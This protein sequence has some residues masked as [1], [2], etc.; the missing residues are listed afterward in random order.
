MAHG[1]GF[2]HGDKRVIPHLSAKEKAMCTPGA[3]SEHKELTSHVQPQRG[4]SDLKG[5]IVRLLKLS[6]GSLSLFKLPRAYHKM[7]GRSLRVSE[8]GVSKLSKLLGWMDDVII[9]EGKD[10]DEFVYLRSSRR[11]GTKAR[12]SR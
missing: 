12:S 8:Y 4:V 6:G 5:Q 3:S 2:E 7:Y 10:R 9:I 11:K 1:E